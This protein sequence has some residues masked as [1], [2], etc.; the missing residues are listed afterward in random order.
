M[1]YLEPKKNEFN[2]IPSSVAKDFEAFE[3]GVLL[4]RTNSTKS[5]LKARSRLLSTGLV[6]N[7]D[8][9]ASHFSHEN[10]RKSVVLSAENDDT[11][12]SKLATKKLILS[13]NLNDKV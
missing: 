1:L 5:R 8:N 12:K 2:A 10:L 4:S 3:N 11:S 9:A 13:K 7:S 6:M